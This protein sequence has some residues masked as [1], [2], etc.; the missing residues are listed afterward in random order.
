MNKETMT[1]ASKIAYIAAALG[2]MSRAM[3]SCNSGHTRTGHTLT[4]VAHVV[5][6]AHP[7]DAAR[8]RGWSSKT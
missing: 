5:S 6:Q 4:R 8:K 2:W 7:E 3:H 1:V